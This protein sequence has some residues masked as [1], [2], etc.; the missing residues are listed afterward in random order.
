MGLQ[1]HS[2]VCGRPVS[3]APVCWK[4][5]PFSFGQS[6]H[7][8]Q[9]SFGRTSQSLF[10]D[11]LSYS[12]DSCTCLCVS[13]TRSVCC[14]FVRAFRSGTVSSPAL[15]LLVKH[16]LVTWGPLRFHLNFKVSFSVSANFVFGVLVRIAPPWGG[17]GIITIRPSCPCTWS[18]F[19]VTCGFS[20]FF[21]RRFVVFIAEV[22]HLFG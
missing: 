13:A 14:S 18:V 10:L 6:R 21:D 11:L 15:F 8:C 22:F 20:D 4:D 16:I 5:C 1:L 3:P 7:L 17:I 9:E 12:T 2:S 19:A